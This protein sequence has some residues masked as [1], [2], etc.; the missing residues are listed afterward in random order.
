VKPKVADADAELAGGWLV[1]V[2][3]P[4]ATVSTVHVT[5][6]AVLRLPAWSTARVSNV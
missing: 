6:V 5:D 1:N 3:V 4:G 2:A